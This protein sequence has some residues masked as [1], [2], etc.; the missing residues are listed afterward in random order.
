MDQYE[1][2]DVIRIECA[3]DGDACLFVAQVIAENCCDRKSSGA[4]GEE[5]KGKLTSRMSAQTSACASK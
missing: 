1:T 4:G 2:L 3:S 5:K